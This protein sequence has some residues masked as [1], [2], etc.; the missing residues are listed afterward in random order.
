MSNCWCSISYTVA[1]ISKGWSYTMIS[2]I[3][4]CFFFFWYFFENILFNI[5]SNFEMENSFHLV[6][7]S[8]LIELKK[9]VEVQV[10]FCHTK[11][12]G[13]QE[14]FFFIWVNKIL[15]KLRTWVANANI[16]F[17]DRWEWC[18][19]GFW[20]GCY[21]SQVTEWTI[22]VCILAG[23]SWCNVLCIDCGQSGKQN[24]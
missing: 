18:V 24:N 14:H 4:S 13:N 21:L 19:N 12:N 3:Y 11:L 17:A 5:L 15:S 16:W 6:S 9:I 20:V 1:T 10:Y 7:L 22:D 8:N 23:N 2:W